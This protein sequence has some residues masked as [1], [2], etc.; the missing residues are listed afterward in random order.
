MLRRLLPLLLLLACD[1][2]ATDTADPDAVPVDAALDVA[3]PDPDM[4]PPDAAPDAAPPDPDAAPDAAPDMAPP[5]P[6]M[7]PPDEVAPTVRFLAPEDGAEV[8]GI[9]QIALDVLDNEGVA[10]VT[11]AFGDAEPVD[12]PAPYARGWDTAGLAPGAYG[13]V[14]TAWDDA[15]N[16]ASAR[17]EVTLEVDCTQEVARCPDPPVVAVDMPEWVTGPIEVE[18]QTEAPRVD[19]LVDG[20]AVGADEEPPFR[21]L[22][23]GAAL[24]EGQHRLVAVVVDAW[25]QV[26][27]AEALFTVDRTPPTVAFVAPEADAT[28][29]GPTRIEVDATDAQQLASVEVFVD[30]A[31]LGPLVDGGIDWVPEYVGGVRTLR[32]VA[33]DAAGHEA[34][35]ER[36]VDV[37]HPLTIDARRCVDG[38]CVAF[39]DDEPELRGAVRFEVDVRDDDGAPQL[40]VLLVDD[41]R[42][43]QAAPPYGVDVDTTELADGPHTFVAS[44]AGARGNRDLRRA[45][46]VNNCDLD[47]DGARSEACDG[48]DCND[49]DPNIN[50]DAADP[51]VDGTDQNCDGTD[52]P[53]PDMA[54][55]DAAVPDAAVEDPGT[56]LPIQNELGPVARVVDLEVPEDAA[57]AR[58]AGCGVVGSNAGTTMR[59]WLARVGRED[60]GNQVRPDLRGDA[61]VVMLVQTP[62]W[63][64]FA[65]VA[66]LDLLTLRSLSGV[67]EGGRTLVTRDSWV[68]PDD[69]DSAGRIEFPFTPIAEDGTFTTGGGPFLMPFPLSDEL[70]LTVR[71][72][73][74]ALTGTL[75]VDAPGIAIAD[76]RVEGYWTEEAIVEWVAQ[77]MAVCAGPRP[78]PDFC[79]ILAFALP[80]GS[81]PEDGIPVLKQFLGGFDVNW[82]D[83]APQECA[84]DC[85]A[86][87]VCFLLEAEGAVA[88]GR[89]GEEVAA[90][91]AACDRVA[92]C[93]LGDACGDFDDR[94]WVA[95]RTRCAG[96]CDPDVAAAVDAAENCAD[97]IAAAVD[98]C[99]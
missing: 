29:P 89:Q 27:Q 33:T 14:A 85:N 20:I 25:G 61:P 49:D 13:I 84:A 46:T 70:A 30:D 64:P 53:I 41:A 39:A 44:V 96:L 76:A 77:L 15:E 48:F 90:C 23:D 63:R 43:R 80:P 6:D 51:D 74:A 32:A 42:H 31:L 34:T 86:V 50:P 36:S 12:V 82:I 38:E 18:A 88:H 10:R 83:G 26:G 57:A 92:D 11:L 45:F 3:P 21:A 7:R 1:D 91:D 93:A 55:P 54:I 95:A 94:D 52:G 66:D 37:N 58:E 35:A 60:L 73:G 8:E 59:A 5:P 99:D 16:E 69:A 71:L 67:R 78:R 81:P 24:A 98:V 28:V 75:S 72:E 97:R 87:S 62:E 19:F 17:V 79:G 4:S 68:D 2:E 56:G 65:E 47:H 22:V 9:V 40:V